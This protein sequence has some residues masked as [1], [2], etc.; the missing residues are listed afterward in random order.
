MSK[1][2]RR[3]LARGGVVATVA[4]VAAGFIAAS[5][6]P[7]FATVVTPAFVQQISG[8]QST[9][10][11]LALTPTANLG[12]GNRLIVEVGV[13]NSTN[14]T[15]TGVTDSA[16]NTYTEL[17][18]VTAADHTELSVWSTP[19]TAGAGARPAITV[20]ASGIAD[21]GAV[22]LEYSGLSTAGGSGSVD[23]TA[24]STGLTT[25]AA[26]VSSGATAAVTATNE[27]ALGFYNDSGFSRALT[28]GAGFTQRANISPASDMQSLVEDQPVS[29]GNTPAATA[30]TGPNT[31]WQMATI[32]FQAGQTGPATVPSAPLSPV[33]VGGN[34]SANLTWTAPSN[35][36]S[37]I[38]SYTVTPHQGGTTLSAINVTGTPVPTSVTVPGLTNGLS[39]TF[40]VTATN[41]IGTGPAAT[42]NAVTPAAG[43]SWSPLQTWPIMPLATHLLYTGETISWDGWQQPQPSVIWDPDEPG[44][45]HDD[46]RA[47]QHLLRRR[48][49][50]AGRSA[51]R[52][53]RLRRPLHRSNRHRRHEH[54]RPGHEHVVAGRQHALPPLVPD[55][56]RALRRPV[57]RPQRQQHERDHLGRYTRGVRPDHQH[58]DAADRR[59]HVDGARRWSTRSATRFRTATSS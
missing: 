27:L 39:Y 58:L 33:A 24:Q 29:T 17:L 15:A 45:L 59:E 13:W 31:Y 34:A 26:T 54:L 28:A 47:G 32:V 6:G 50:P 52:Y 38:T 1:M 18:H 41:T 51:A 42:S 14:A 55:G 11:T 7:S 35:G 12:T 56:H 8:H 5:G 48:R 46:Q 49:R 2:S 37:P 20:K 23:K 43:G 53:R 44:Q 57:P 30:G 16:G 10:A 19:I 36:G 4:V 3:T 21:I 22:A 25:A 40:A 9:K